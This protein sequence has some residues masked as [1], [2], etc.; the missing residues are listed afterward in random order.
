MSEENRCSCCGRPDCGMGAHPTELAKLRAE[1]DAARLECERFR[2]PSRTMEDYDRALLNLSDAMRQ[3][4]RLLNL[5][6][7]MREALDESLT[8]P[9]FSCC[10]KPCSNCKRFVDLLQQGD[11]ITSKGGAMSEHEINCGFAEGV[12]PPGDEV[13]ERLRKEAECFQWIA[14]QGN[15]LRLS[16]MSIYWRVEIIQDGRYKYWYG[17]TLLAAILSARQEA[18]KCSHNRTDEDGICRACGADRRGI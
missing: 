8:Q 14:K 5:C 9:Y 12:Q 10:D 17:P 3:R 18:G 15:T 16:E 6:V 13:A 1:R 4:D 7:K 11:R 2:R